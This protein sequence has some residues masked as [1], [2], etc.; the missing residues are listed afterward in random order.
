MPKL[1]AA[2]TAPPA[3]VANAPH[4]RY[5]LAPRVSF[6]HQGHS[7]HIRAVPLAIGDVMGLTPD[8]FAKGLLR[9]LTANVHRHTT[10]TEPAEASRA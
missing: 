6:P 8:E 2:R 5:V 3:H 10:G 9:R 4:G 1:P 7:H